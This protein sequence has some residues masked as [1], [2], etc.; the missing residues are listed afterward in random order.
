M[1]A[2]TPMTPRIFVSHS[3]QD[4]AFTMR[5]V[6]DLE[7]AGAVVWV[8]KHDIKEGDFL[9]RINEG[10][11]RSDWLVLI[12]TSH[13]LTSP[14]VEMEVN[15]AQNRVLYRQMRG[16]LR[17]IAAP[18][19]PRTVPPTWA[20]LQYYDATQDYQT[21]VAALLDAIRAGDARWAERERQ[22]PGATLPATPLPVAQQTAT[23]A[24]RLLTRA[25]AAYTANDWHAVADVTN[26]LLADDPNAMTLEGWRMRGR[27]L[28]E[29]RRL[30]DARSALQTAY[31]D[32]KYDLATIRLLARASLALDDTTQAA[33]LLERALGLADD[34]ETKLDILREYVPTLQAL[35]RQEEA[36]GRVEQALL[37]RPNDPAWLALKLALLQTLHR[38]DEAHAVAQHLTALPTATAAD[39]LTLARLIRERHP[40]PPDAGDIDVRKTIQYALDEA[41]RRADAAQRAAI[42][43]A[44]RELLPPPK[45]IPPEWFPQELG[46]LQYSAQWV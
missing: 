6:A 15:A 39:W 30:P 4:E 41:D 17:L 40:S 19:D 9:K 31:N 44:R 35:G 1:P 16:V 25:A 26:I 12:E 5:V 23:P 29:L 11:A 46:K 33:P 13:S 8:D 32:D 38:L 37:L 22:S 2:T 27:A 3:H 10:L 18:R 36:L 21:A 42:T 28:L 24:G 20:T 34:T 45:Q 43:Q 14:A 7:H